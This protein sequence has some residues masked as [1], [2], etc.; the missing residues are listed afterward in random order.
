MAYSFFLTLWYAFL[1][2]VNTLDEKA[3]WGIATD[4]FNTF[5]KILYLHIVHY[6]Y[7][8]LKFFVFVF[9]KFLEPENQ[10]QQKENV[11]NSWSFKEYQPND[12][13]TKI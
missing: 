5:Y 9:F 11:E 2:N 3:T 4:P 7:S 13:H 6:R 10:F 1:V 8:I 12:R